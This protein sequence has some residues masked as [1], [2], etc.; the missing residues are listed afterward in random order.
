MLFNISI[1]SF[2]EVYTMYRQL[3]N[4]VIKLNKGGDDTVTT[5]IQKWGNSLAVRIPA[6]FAEQLNIQQGSKVE[7]TV[8]DQEIMI[9]PKRVKPTLDELLAQCL[10][11]NR[12]DEIEFGTL[13][14]ELL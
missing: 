14:K 5:K 13:G 7:M 3:V 2:Q 6:H 8:T 12:H 10:P 4:E 11:E 1:I 9:T